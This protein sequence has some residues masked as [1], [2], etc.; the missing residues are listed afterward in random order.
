MEGNVPI[1]ARVAV[2]RS[3][4]RLRDMT[5]PCS[6]RGPSERLVTRISVKFAY[7]TVHEG[8]C[9]G[10]TSRGRAMCI[11]AED[12]FAASDDV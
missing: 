5:R 10:K 3:K 11:S 8:V 6:R 4:T 12:G 1:Q 2:V 7:F 9:Q